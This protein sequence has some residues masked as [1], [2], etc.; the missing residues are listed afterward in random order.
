MEQVSNLLM[1][2]ES[3]EKYGSDRL[4]DNSLI[5]IILGE[6]VYNTLKNNGLNTLFKIDMKSD[7]ELRD[8]GISKDNILKIKALI[9][10]CRRGT[11]IETVKKLDDPGI[12]AGLCN[13]LVNLDQEILRVICVNNHL[14]MIYQEDVFKGGLNE[15]IVHPRE[16][17]KVALKCSASCFFI[18]HN[19]PSGDTTPSKHDLNITELIKEAGK[20][21]KINLLDHIIV[22]K[23]GFI[24]FKEKGLI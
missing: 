18:I 2:K 6:K 11:K 12:I 17:L 23:K 15:S 3:F 4:D 16:I 20:I 14:Q 9:S 22:G 21:L 24:S 10:L 13:D 1:I 7:D 5:S 8:I 19:H